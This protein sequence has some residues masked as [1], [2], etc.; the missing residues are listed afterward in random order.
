MFISY[1]ETSTRILIHT[2]GL[3]DSEVQRMPNMKATLFSTHLSYLYLRK[4]ETRNF[5]NSQLC[6]FPVQSKKTL[7]Q[8]IQM[9][10]P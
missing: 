1:F 8:K 3:S 7:L 5:I 9:K 4:L 2:C 10:S 6:G